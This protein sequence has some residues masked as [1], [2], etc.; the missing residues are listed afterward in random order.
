MDF[1]VLFILDQAC[2]ID[3]QLAVYAHLLQGAGLQA[4]IQ[5]LWWLIEIIHEKVTVTQAQQWKESKYKQGFHDQ[6]SFSY[7]ETDFS[8]PIMEARI[9]PIPS[10]PSRQPTNIK[11]LVWRKK[12]PAPSPANSPPPMASDPFRFNVVFVFI[13]KVLKINK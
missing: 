3:Y 13:I 8:F 5:I 10:P 11:A 7:S 1:P 4:V 2:C 9:R 6:A 12:N